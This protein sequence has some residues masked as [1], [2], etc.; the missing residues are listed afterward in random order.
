MK[1]TNNKLILLDLGNNIGTTQIAKNNTNQLDW[2]INAVIPHH[3][4]KTVKL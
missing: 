1:K 2:D 4:K 3:L